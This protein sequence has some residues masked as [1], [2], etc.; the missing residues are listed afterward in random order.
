MLI[1]IFCHVYYLLLIESFRFSFHLT[2]F[3]MIR[4]PPLS[5]M[6]R[7]LRRDCPWSGPFHGHVVW[8][9]Q[10]QGRHCIS[11]V[12]DRAGSSGE[13]TFK[14]NRGPIERVCHRSL[15]RGGRTRFVVLVFRDL[16]QRYSI[17]GRENKIMRVFTYIN[18]QYITV[19]CR[20]RLP[21]NVI[22]CIL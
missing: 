21:Y 6:V 13:R 16:D 8:S 18:I 5:F 7:F 14:R 10:H 9:Q 1:Q 19:P 11:K 3:S 12:C 22:Y 17:P 4:F 15:L 20:R 2:W